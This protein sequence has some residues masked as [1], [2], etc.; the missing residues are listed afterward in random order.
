MR[1]RRGKEFESEFII[2]WQSGSEQ[3]QGAS[4]NQFLNCEMNCHLPEVIVVTKDHE[5]ECEIPFY[6]EIINKILRRTTSVNFFKQK[7]WQSKFPIFNCI[8]PAIPGNITFYIVSKYQKQLFE[9]LIELISNS[10]IQGRRFNLSRIFSAEFRLEIDSSLTYLACEIVIPIDSQQDLDY[11]RNNLVVIESEISK[12][13]NAL[14][15]SKKK[16]FNI[17]ETDAKTTLIQKNIIYLL[18]RKPRLFDLNLMNEMRH[19]LVICPNNFKAQRSSTHLTRIICIQYFFRKLLVKNCLATN[20]RHIYLKIFRSKIQDRKNSVLG[21]IVGFNFLREKEVF[22]KKHLIR[23]IKNH[24]PNVVMVENSFFEDRRSSERFCTLY[25]EIEKDS[26][27]KFHSEEIINL[28]KTLQADL[29][30]GIEQLVHS[31]F[32]PR[33][34]EEILRNI[35]T[36]SAEIKTLRDLP[37]V[38]INFEEQT[39]SKLCFNIIVVRIFKPCDESIQLLFQK[40]ETALEYVHVRS[41]TIA[42]MRNKY[43]K[44]SNVFTVKLN[45]EKFIRRDHSIDLNKARQIV[46]LELLKVIGEFR[47]F[48]GGMISKQNE[49]LTEVKSLMQGK[50]KL[51]ELI[52]DNFFFSIKP[53]VMRTVL[54]PKALKILFLMLEEMLKKPLPNDR[55]YLTHSISDASSAIMFIKSEYPVNI[56]EITHALE[57]LKAQTSE[58]A[59]AYVQIHDQNY[60]GFIFRSFDPMRK[61]QFHSIIY[62]TI[63]CSYS[64]KICNE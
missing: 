14:F 21:I 39:Y 27:E 41:K 52:F 55:Y 6:K 47:D 58:L 7:D 11:I 12:A 50:I 49:L 36:L 53:I 51:N 4:T 64:N 15:N 34:E 31:I 48:C 60:Y 40:H 22:E 16:L 13:I 29:I 37:Q 38:M 63:C 42:Q 32:M 5:E 2:R 28:R 19:I 23:A 9:C 1:A 26:K 17:Q 57:V 59:H 54:E 25:L 10:L 20:K 56:D 61:E 35:V 45:K 8:C 43:V 18:E 24:I 33:N 44:E 62:Q 46:V 3:L 30:D